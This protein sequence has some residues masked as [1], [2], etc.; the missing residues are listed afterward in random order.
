M[1]IG[2]GGQRLMVFP[3]EQLIATF[4]GWDILQDPAVDAELANRLLPA[5]ITAQCGD[6]IDV[7]P[8]LMHALFAERR[9]TRSRAKVALLHLVVVTHPSRLRV[10]VCGI[11]VHRRL[12]EHS[13]V[14]PKN[15]PV[16]HPYLVGR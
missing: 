7:A 12:G 8:G 15:Q 2:F 11:P 6:L 16:F 1:G 4:T 9:L 10:L 5:V 14:V 3:E 13:V